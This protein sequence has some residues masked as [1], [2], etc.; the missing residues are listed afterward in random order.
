MW[1][2]WTAVF[3]CSIAACEAVAQGPAA[4]SEL[5]TPQAEA[6]QPPPPPRKPDQQ[7]LVPEDEE[8]EGPEGEE[9][10][11][12]N[13]PTGP[14]RVEPWAISESR[15]RYDSDPPPKPPESTLNLRL[16]LTGERLV[17][18]ASRGEPIIEEMVDDTGA[19]LKTSADYEPRELTKVYPLRAGK[20][21]RQA[22]YAGLNVTAPAS[23]REARKL[24]KV[25]G[26]VNVVFAVD[27]DEIM[28]D[29]PLQYLG[30][31]LQHPRLQELGIK[32]KV[33]TPDE[34]AMEKHD[35]GGIAL[36]FVDGARKHLNKAEFF[37][38]WLKPL[39]A[40]ERPTET[41]EGE[42]YV[43]YAV[44]V[45]KI[46]ADTQMLMKLYPQIEEEKI[47]FELENI[48]LP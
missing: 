27:T 16:K 37:D 45:G 28:I 22:G 24:T 48:E 47:T 8:V 34:G 19:V 30:G 2:I 6:P 41:P 3:C 29:N 18:L 26:Y 13:L 39:Y 17:H 4:R 9:P 20:R 21:M 12:I 36:Q 14:M 38:G 31:Y 5:A 40:R 11:E 25:R 33:I 44:V 7:P 42:E 1:Y 23:S 32:I 43:F 35:V 10:I 15:N 46:D